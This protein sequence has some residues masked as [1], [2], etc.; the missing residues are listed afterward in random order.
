MS[1]AAAVPKP[2]R[3]L[4][5]PLAWLRANPVI[6]KEL[7]ARMRGSRA[8][9]IL[10]I[11]LGL[12]ALVIATAYLLFYSSHHGGTSASTATLIQARREFGQLIFWLILG[13]ETFGV[14]VLSPSMTSSS[15]TSERE[16]QTFDLLHTT[17]LSARDLVW[18]KF[19]SGF[20]FILL[21]LVVTLPLQSL[22]LLFGGVTLPDLLVY[23]GILVAMAFGFCAVGVFCSSFFKSSKVANG[24]GFTIP[25][26]WVVLL[27]GLFLILLSMFY[28]SS[29]IFNGSSGLT[30]F[31]EVFRVV[32]GMVLLSIS[33]IATIVITQESLRS[34]NSPFVYS[35]YA[36]G[37][38]RSID[39][40][41]PW[42]IFVALSL[43]VGLLLLRISARLVKR[44]DN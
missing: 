5:S 21:L 18:G 1:E 39:L 25:I 34:G 41:A 33:P 43:L 40:P 19:L 3:P 38:N 9:L 10:S 4:P 24:L 6:L 31:E 32:V 27:P 44:T 20:L 16:H 22:A 12:M 7:R 28:P 8:A 29:W 36:S 23:L 30:S 13:L 35:Y 15:I 2:H 26:V 37:A 11:Y 14:C 17:L 42:L